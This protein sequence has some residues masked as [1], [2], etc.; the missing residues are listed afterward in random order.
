MLRIA[1]ADIINTSAKEKSVKGKVEHLQKHDT[2]PLRQVLRLIYDEDIEFLVPDSKPPFKEN[3]LVDLETLLYREARR[4]RIFFLGGGYDALNTNRREAL[5]IQ[6]LEDLYIPDA[7]MLSENMI[8]HTP[9]KGL[10]KKTLELAFP[11]LFTDPLNF[12]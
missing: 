8:S 12:K 1:I 4:L 2:I 10:T 7:N 3:E 9:I 5:F 11:T 6:L